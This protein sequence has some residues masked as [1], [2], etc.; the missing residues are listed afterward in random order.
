MQPAPG[1]T[2]HPPPHPQY[3][4]QA[5]VPGAP[6]TGLPGAIFRDMSHPG[7]FVGP[8]MHCAAH[9][10]ASALL[11]ARNVVPT[12][13][14]C[15]P[16]PA[17]SRVSAAA[18][19][20]PRSQPDTLPSSGGDGAEGRERQAHNR[21]N[22]PQE[23]RQWCLDGNKVWESGSARKGVQGRPLRGGERPA[24]PNNR[25]EPTRENVDRED[26]GI[27]HNSPEGAFQTH[28]SSKGEQARGWGGV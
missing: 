6:P 19:L 24:G 3:L 14:P 13:P 28:K 7:L 9:P 15:W 11:P 18:P 27:M 8:G 16:V 20:P 10:P 17:S 2:C 4:C 23:S 22:V 26:C 21:V 25:Q 1:V 12:D 5:T